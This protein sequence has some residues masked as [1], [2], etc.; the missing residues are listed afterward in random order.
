MQ[1]WK[2]PYT[3]KFIWKQYYENFTFLIVRILELFTYKVHIF[4]KMSANFNMFYKHFAIFT[5]R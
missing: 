5:G 1:I 3:F 4:L 2:S